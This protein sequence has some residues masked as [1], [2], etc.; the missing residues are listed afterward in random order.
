MQCGK[1]YNNHAC[2]AS[3]TEAQRRE[4]LVLG[5]LEYGGGQE[6]DCVFQAEKRGV[7]R[8]QHEQS[9]EV[10]RTFSVLKWFLLNLLHSLATGSSVKKEL[11]WERGVGIIH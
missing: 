3:A 6:E 8:V 2:V 4:G 11:Q 5:E 7:S 9:Q 1:C 10:F